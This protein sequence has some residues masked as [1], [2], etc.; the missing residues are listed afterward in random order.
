[1]AK[2]EPSQPKSAG[3]AA[4]KAFERA[5]KLLGRLEKRLAA[6]RKDEA[7]R[8]RQLADATG[9]DVARR[10][11]QRRGPHRVAA[12]RAVG[13]DRGECPGAG[14]PDRQRH[15]PRGGPGCSDRGPGPNRGQGHL[16]AQGR[17]GAQARRETGQP[18]ANEDPGNGRQARRTRE[19]RSGREAG[20][21]E[22]ARDQ[23]YVRGLASDHA[24]GS[25]A[26]CDSPSTTGSGD[27]RLTHDLAHPPPLA[28][29][30]STRQRRSRPVQQL[31]RRYRRRTHR[32]VSRRTG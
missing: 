2:T 28:E 7:K 23:G 18:A 31:S 1:M 30:P 22:A 25:Q 12:D 16:R 11:G 24:R 6:A 3:R 32:S 29:V 5:W 14:P 26:G 4:T 15:G 13:A 19:T 27:P 20:R 21:C 10:G 17:P 8:R 9:P